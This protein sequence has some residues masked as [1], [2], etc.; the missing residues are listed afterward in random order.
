MACI[1]RVHADLVRASG[2]DTHLQQR[3]ALAEELHRP[4][5]T[6]R[7]LAARHHL[8]GTLA[9]DPQVGAQRRI[10]ALDAQLPAAAHQCEVTLL[11]AI[12][13]IVTTQ[14]RVQAAQH[15]GPARD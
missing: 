11:E 1:S 9:T 8:D 2:F 10:D 14:Q 15:R 4:E 13:L 6:E 5:F 12:A 3:C 7:R